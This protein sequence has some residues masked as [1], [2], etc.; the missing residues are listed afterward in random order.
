MVQKA[1]AI[2]ENWGLAFERCGV[3]SFH[4][5]YMWCVSML[6]PQPLQ[7]VIMLKFCVNECLYISY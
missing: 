2:G 5:E 7:I 4:L 3:T 1:N 6:G